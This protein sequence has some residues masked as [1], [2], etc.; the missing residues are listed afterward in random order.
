MI[1]PF[2][3]LQSSKKSTFMRHINICAH[4]DR[5]YNKEDIEKLKT[6]IVLLHKEKEVENLK[7]EKELLSAKLKSTEKI[8]EVLTEQNKTNNEVAVVNSY[9]VMRTI[10]FLNKYVTNAPKLSNFM[11][12]FEDPYSFYIDYEENDRIRKEVE[13][14]KKPL[15]IMYYDETKMTKDDYI[16]DHICFFT[17]N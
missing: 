10:N 6:E 7:H 2:C 13:E 1:C 8:N 11:D 5:K 9:N 4:K 16:I 3:N 15:E 17:R 14:K 12:E